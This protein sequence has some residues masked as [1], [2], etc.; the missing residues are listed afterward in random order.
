MSF[1]EALYAAP[2]VRA[3]PLQRRE[4]R[5]VPTH[6]RAVRHGNHRHSRRGVLNPHRPHHHNVPL[7]SIPHVVAEA[8]TELFTRGLREE[9][10]LPRV[11]DPDSLA[12]FTEDNVRALGEVLEG[13]AVGQ[14]SEVCHAHLRQARQ[15]PQPPP[16]LRLINVHLDRVAPARVALARVD[17]A[18]RHLVG[19]G[20]GAL[21]RHCHLEEVDGARELLGA[22]HRPADDE[23]GGLGGRDAPHGND[24]VARELYYVPPPGLDVLDDGGHQ[25]VDR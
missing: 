10:D 14:E 22:P 3:A 18:A 11:D 25:P 9:I 15:V 21:R 1:E 17:V 8:P 19:K 5:A 6:E 2:E 7:S 24:G 23:R 4:R 20:H 13:A 12:V 16:H